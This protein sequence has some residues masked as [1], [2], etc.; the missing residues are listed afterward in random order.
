MDG[1]RIVHIEPGEGCV[2]A[3]NEFWT[4]EC[5]VTSELMETTP[6]IVGCILVV[7]L[8]LVTAIIFFLFCRVKR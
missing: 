3:D 7:T 5:D 6:I 2:L 1:S 4:E 8:L